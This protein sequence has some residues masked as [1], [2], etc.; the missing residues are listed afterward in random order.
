[1]ITDND[2]IV[3]HFTVLE[4]LRNLRAQGQLDFKTF[5]D[6]WAIKFWLGNNVHFIQRHAFDVNSHAAAS[7]ASDKILTYL[8]LSDSG[9][10]AVPH[11][12]LTTGARPQADRAQL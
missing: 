8:L 4:A 2:Y 11:F 7:L 10:P 1:M 3:Q 12:L 9:V 5:S 6:E